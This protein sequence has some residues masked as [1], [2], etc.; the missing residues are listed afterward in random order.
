[1]GG[2][3]GLQVRERLAGVLEVGQRVDHRHGGGGGQLDDP[4]LAERADHDGVDVPRQDRAGVGDRLAPPELE[5]RRGQRE[6]VATELGDR[7]LERHARAGRGLLED[8]CHRASGQRLAV[9]PAV[10]A[11][12]IG[13]EPVGEVEQVDELVGVEVVDGEEVGG[14]AATGLS[15]GGGRRSVGVVGQSVGRGGRSDGRAVVRQVI[16]TRAGGGRP[17]PPA[18]R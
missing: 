4:V 15:G 17:P 12:T 9:G 16:V 10:V 11:G 8:Q 13:L 2:A 1:V 14:N 5:L 6:R 3:Q 18:L 7:D